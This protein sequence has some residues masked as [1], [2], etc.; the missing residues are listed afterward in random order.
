MFAHSFGLGLAGMFIVLFGTPV[1]HR[2][3]ENNIR[4]LFREEVKNLQLKLH[5]RARSYSAHEIVT[6]VRLDSVSCT[7]GPYDY[8]CF[9]FWVAL[10]MSIRCI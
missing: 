5:A 1:K 9:L 6:N 4:F 8:P 3:L 10:K 7:A 2:L